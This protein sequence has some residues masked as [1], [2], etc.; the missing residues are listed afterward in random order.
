VKQ[1]NLFLIFA[2]LCFSNNISALSLFED[3]GTT[4]MAG[5]EITPSAITLGR[6]GAGVAVAEDGAY[7]HINPAGI[8]NTDGD[9]IYMSHA[10]LFENSRSECLNAT[11]LYEKLPIGVTLYYRKLGEAPVIY[12]GSDYNENNVYSAY[13][14][15]V[16]FSSGVK[17]E[18]MKIGFSLRIMRQEVWNYS[19][20]ALAADGGLLVKLPINGLSAGASVINLGYASA[21]DNTAYPLSTVVR[22]GTAYDKTLKNGIRLKALTDV[23]ASNDGSLSIPVGLEAGNRWLTVRSGWNV[24]HDTQSYSAGL[25]IKLNSIQIDY[26]YVHFTENLSENSQPQFFS[27]SF[28]LN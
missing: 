6:G 11:L 19:S 28:F 10:N 22:A 13:D 5:Y 17:T 26:A 9:R 24:L 23:Q 7:S 16:A 27:L 4:V 2:L 21:F 12:D 3:R 1:I 8:F 20:T 14:A 15:A 25:S 18:R